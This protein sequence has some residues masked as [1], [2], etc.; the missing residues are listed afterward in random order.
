MP[1]WSA[2]QRVDMFGDHMG[3]YAPR[4]VMMIE[5]G[6]QMPGDDLV[7]E[8]KGGARAAV[9]DEDTVPVSQRGEV[10]GAALAPAQMDGQDESGRGGG[11]GFFHWMSR[12]RRL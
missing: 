9:V 11:R 5:F 3:S 1:A 2:T 8:L 10:L 4:R 6:K 7:R 12:R